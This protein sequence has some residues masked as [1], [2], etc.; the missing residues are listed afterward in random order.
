MKGQTFGWHAVW[1]LARLAIG[2]FYRVDR[3]GPS[4]P[5]GGLLLVANH[6]NM[7]MDPSLIQTTA[8]RPIR[9]LAKSTLFRDHVLS[10]LVRHSGSI[11]V[12]RRI[13]PGVDV[14]RNVEMFSA[15]Q[16]ALANGDAICLFPE[17]ISHSTGRLQPLRSGVARMALASS[18][19]GYRAAIMPVGLNFDRSPL[20]RSRVTAVFGGAFNY[21][22]LIE[23]YRRDEQSAVRALTARIAQRLAPLVLQADPRRDLSV[24]DRIDRL[25]TSA[26]GVSRAPEERDR[27]RRLVAKGLDQLRDRDPDMLNSVLARVEAYDTH[28]H[29]FGL[30]DR[31]VDQRTSTLAVV[32]FTIREGAFSLILLPLSVGVVVLFSL[33]YWITGYVGRKYAPDRQSRATWQILWGAPIYCGWIGMLVTMAGVASGASAALATAALLPV[34]AV[35]GLTAL[36]RQTAVWR[37]VRSYL[38]LRQTPLR[39]RVRLKR[40]RAEIADVLERVRDWLEERESTGERAGGPRAP[41]SNPDGP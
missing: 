17:G 1:L 14:S 23:V 4:L 20:F 27:R 16:Q 35:V 26:R 30:R 3:I 37:L 13:D 33:P 15:V 22:D 24:V 8:G 2:L 36:E 31:D 34:L 32:N 39:A 7:V 38:A 5:D 9:F 28:L 19:R 21:D 29:Q 25:Y 12:Y 41:G 10:P 11:P 40:Q 6:P 18:E